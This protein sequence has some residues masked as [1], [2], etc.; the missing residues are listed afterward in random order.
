MWCYGW[1]NGGVGGRGAFGTPA[2]LVD[3]I[4]FITHTGERVDKKM[5]YRAERVM[6]VSAREAA[7]EGSADAFYNLYV[8]MFGSNGI[9]MRYPDGE[10]R[11]N[12]HIIA[13]ASGSLQDALRECDASFSHYSIMQ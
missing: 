3:T 10:W 12:A 6:H 9:V 5:Y 2:P 8:G 11:M 7:E 13:G 1:V 4:E